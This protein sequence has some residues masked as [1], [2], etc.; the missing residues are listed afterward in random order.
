MIHHSPQGVA[1]VLDTTASR[2]FSLME[3]AAEFVH[4]Y[5]LSHPDSAE[6]GNAPDTG[7]QANG[8]HSAR[9]SCLNILMS[10]TH[11]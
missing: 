7:H 1:H 3:T 10:C 8:E 6:A 2:D 4:R 9:C 5:R 11:G